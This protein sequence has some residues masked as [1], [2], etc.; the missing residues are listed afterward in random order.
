MKFKYILLTMH[1][2]DKTT[3]QKAFN[4]HW[5]EL[6][7]LLK[8]KKGGGGDKKKKRKKTQT[9][10]KKNQGGQYHLGQASV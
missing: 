3:L 1:P 8:K 2:F 9:R 5:H 10:K 4:A 6:Y 7:T